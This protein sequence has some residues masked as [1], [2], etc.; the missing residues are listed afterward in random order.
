MTT[1]PGV[2]N[3]VD[4]KDMLR[5]IQADYDRLLMDDSPLVA[6]ATLWRALMPWSGRRP[7]QHRS[8]EKDFAF[9]ESQPDALATSDIRGVVDFRFYHV[10]SRA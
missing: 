2:L 6:S 7:L 1:W 8:F 9:H 5:D 4:V 10:C 3:A